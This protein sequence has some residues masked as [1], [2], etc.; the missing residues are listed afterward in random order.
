MDSQSITKKKRDANIELLRI[1]AMLM[2]ITLH[3]NNQSKALLVLGEVSMSMCLSAD[4]I[5][6]LRK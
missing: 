6:L 2:I 5:C 3:F 4:I 1:V